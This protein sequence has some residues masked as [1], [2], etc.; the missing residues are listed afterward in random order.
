MTEKQILERLVGI[1]KQQKLTQKTLAKE[2]GV[3]L[4]HL[5]LVER[6]KTVL[7]IRRFLQICNVLQV[8]PNK[9]LEEE[10]KKTTLQEMLMEMLNK[11][12]PEEMELLVGVAQ[13]MGDRHDLRP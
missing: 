12:L 4:P 13:M 7:T 10:H 9:V 8:E 1:R 6:G 11:L 5:S 3:S 2:I